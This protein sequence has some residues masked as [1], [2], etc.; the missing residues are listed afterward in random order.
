MN[1]SDRIQQL[2]KARGLSQEELSAHLNVSRQAVSKWE[3]GQSLP[4]LDRIVA[5]SAFFGVT[6]DYLL[7]GA[8][9][10]EP[11]S[12]DKT[13]VGRILMVAALL[14]VYIGLFAAFAS[15]P[16]EQ[17]MTCIWGS[18]II[19]AVGVAAHFIG[20]QFSGPPAPAV[21]WP[22]IIGCLFL[23]LSL[24]SGLASLVIFRRSGL[25]PYPQSL[26]HALL[27]L[28]LYA[29]SLLLIHRIQKRRK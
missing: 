20:R 9:P 2:R 11:S 7:T 24:L 13:A 14:F 5:L 25:A 12:G 3:S 6:T 23:P 16:Q 15:W 29:L 10:P 28:L 17:S 8:A 19:Q 1:L 26:P 22:G 21:L 4:D 18:L 27:F